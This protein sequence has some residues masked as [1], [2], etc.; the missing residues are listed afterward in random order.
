MQLNSSQQTLI[1]YAGPAVLAGALA[2]LAFLFIGQAPLMRSLGLAAAI[3]GIS[4]ALRNMG[5][6]MSVVG[7]LTL[8]FSPAFWEQVSA[9]GSAVATIVMALGVAGILAIGMVIFVQRPYVVMMAALAAFALIFFSQIGAAR[10]LRLTVLAS[11]WIIYLLVQSVMAANPR[12]EDDTRDIARWMA[13]MRAATLLLLSVA[14]IN[15]PLFV[16]FVPAV[17]LGFL[18]SHVRLPV[19]YWVT[20][21]SV[22]LIGIFGLLN[23]Y[24]APE[25][26]G[27]S[28]EAVY[29][30]GS[31]RYLVADGFYDGGRWL[32]TLMILAAQFSWVG[33]LLGVV[34]LSRLARWYPP[35]GTV[36]ICGYA[37]FFIFGLLYFGKDRMTLMLPLV[38]MQVFLMCYAVYAAGQW[39]AKTL[40]TPEQRVARITA[41]ALFAI[42]PAL[43]LIQIL[44]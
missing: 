25:W 15:D 40:Q 10:S 6:L 14:I 7:G 32:S 22:T 34:G 20:M 30:G 5:A 28:I 38:I 35:V 31:V 41:P 13:A 19:W 27:A 36:M 39:A 2:W 29:A 17:A 18:Q 3:V 33:L 8:A 11:T 4:L 12:P 23:T 42:L 37:A 24:I 16:L 21:G 43:L 9:G 44:T 1:Q 26:W